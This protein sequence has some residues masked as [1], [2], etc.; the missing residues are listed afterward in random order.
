MQKKSGISLI[1]LSITILVMAILAAT[2]IIALENSGIIKRA[3]ST[4]TQQNYADEYTRLQIVKNGILTD[5]LGTITVEEYIAALRSKDMLEPG[6]TT[7]A[8]G[9]ITVTTKSGFEVI[10]KANGNSDLTVTIDGYT[11]ANNNNSGNV[12][13][14][15]GNNNQTPGTPVAPT[16]PE[17][18]VITSANYP[19]AGTVDDYKEWSPIEYWNK[20]VSCPQASKYK[21]IISEDTLLNYDWVDDFGDALGIS[22]YTNT[23]DDGMGGSGYDDPSVYQGK[24]GILDGLNIGGIDIYWCSYRSGV[25]KISIYPLDENGNYLTDYDYDIDTTEW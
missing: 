25:F 9:S 24:E 8:D 15:S 17:P 14:N 1:V 7:S 3:K 22:D 6:Q 20:K 10:L 18:I 11:Q 19:N 2:A 12:G 21:V 23:G 13:S 16:V 5:N 4:T